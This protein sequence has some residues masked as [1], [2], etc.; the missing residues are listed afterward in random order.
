LIREI[1]SDVFASRDHREKTALFAALGYTKSAPA[2]RFLAAQFEQKAGLFQRGRTSELKL[3]A[4]TGLTAHGTLES[5]AVLKREIQNRSNG[6]DVMLAARQAAL[7][8]REKLKEGGGSRGPGGYPS[9]SGLTEDVS[10]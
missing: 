3:L 2:L 4:I 5:F 1:G 9:T 6:K 8:L 10:S 7:K